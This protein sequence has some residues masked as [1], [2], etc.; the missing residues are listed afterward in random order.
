MIGVADLFSYFLLLF[1]K[2]RLC[3]PLCCCPS[4]VYTYLAQALQSFHSNK[5]LN[6]WNGFFFRF[7]NISLTL[8]QEPRMTSQKSAVYFCFQFVILLAIN[9]KTW[10]WISLQGPVCFKFWKQLCFNGAQKNNT[11]VCLKLAKLVSKRQPRFMIGGFSGSDS[12]PDGFIHCD[13][14]M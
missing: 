5:W 12:L 11:N 10:L 7:N 14:H 3:V 6:S 1:Q 8:I 13:L 2:K 9:E 4:W